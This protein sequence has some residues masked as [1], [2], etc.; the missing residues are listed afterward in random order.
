MALDFDKHSDLSLEIYTAGT[1]SRL[2]ICANVLRVIGDDGI[3]VAEIPQLSG[4][5][6]MSID[7]WMGILDKCGY[8][9]VATDPAR[10]RRVTRLTT[11]GVAARDA[12]FHWM[13]SVE[14]RWPDARSSAAV[15]RLRQAAERIVG[16]PGPGSLLW[17]GIE[18]YPDGWR[19]QVPPQQVLP[20][21]PV[22][23][24]RGGFPDGS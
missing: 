12:Y 9:H 10:R 16:E 8:A 7:N 1:G 21:F 20:R 6:K 24:P 18:P 14:R 2:P 19:S 11:R 4:V 17:K 13:E 3:A 23:S 22:V 15:K 5:D